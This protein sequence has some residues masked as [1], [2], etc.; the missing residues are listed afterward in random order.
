MM[1][2]VSTLPIGSKFTFE[3]GIEFEVM[4][5]GESGTSV[6]KTK[7]VVATFT[8]PKTGKGKK[9]TGHAKP[10]QISAGSEVTP[11]P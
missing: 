9:I 8:D 1:V 3:S 2:K 6:R 5:H 7:L 4:A 10:M 11:V